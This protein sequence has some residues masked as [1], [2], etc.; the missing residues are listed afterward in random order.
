[1][2]ALGIEQGLIAGFDRGARTAVA[3]A[4]LW[5]QRCKA[6]VSVSGYILA[7]LAAQ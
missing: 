1:M 6:I 3:V 2:D 7:N 5:P 4:A